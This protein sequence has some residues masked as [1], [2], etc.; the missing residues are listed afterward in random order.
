MDE[1]KWIEA[2]KDVKHILDGAGVKYWL[3]WGTLLGA[4]RE[5][6]IIPWDTDIDLGAMCSEADKLIRKIPELEQKGFKVDITDF[7]FIMFRKPVAISIALYRIRGNKAWLLRCKKASN[8]NFITRYFEMLSDR[9][10]YR[11]LSSKSKMP[12]RGRVAF[13]IIPDLAEHTIRK[14]LFRM[15]E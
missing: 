3:E 9:I 4:V 7:R 14:I 5:G 15:S 11:N 2:L 10:L 1:K 8:F 12:L 13:A 6:R